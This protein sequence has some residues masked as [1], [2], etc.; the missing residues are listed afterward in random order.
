M[1]LKTGET[2]APN[3]ARPAD[4][5]RNDTAKA[6][7]RVCVVVMG[8]LGRSPRMLNHALELATAGAEVDLVGYA[9]RE[10]PS[11]IRDHDR[12]RCHRLKDS[13]PHWRHK[14][15]QFLFLLVASWRLAALATRL[16]WRLLW[17][18]E[19]PQY[20]LV[21]TP[22]AL[23]ALIVVWVASRLR[24]ATFVID[25]HNFG[26]TVLASRLGN[27]HW[28][29][30]AACRLEVFLARR[31]DMHF[32]VSEAMRQALCDEWGLAATYRLYDL[33]R[34]IHD[35]PG[36]EE[37][38]SI[39]SRISAQRVRVT[40]GTNVEWSV[41][42]EAGGVPDT[43]NAASEAVYSKEGR[44]FGSSEVALAVSS[45]SW[46]DDEDFG[47]LL[48]A[49]PLVDGLFVEQARTQGHATSLRLE[50]L[51]TGDGPRR[52]EFETSARAL[53]LV[54]IR[55]ATAWLSAED[56]TRLLTAADVGICLHRS[57]SGMDL[58]MKLSDMLGAGLPV[59][60]LDYGGA[61][62]E[63]L[64]E[65]NNAVLFHSP[66]SLAE[67]IYQVLGNF[68]D[69]PEKLRTLSRHIRL[70]PL[71]TWREEWNHVAY[72]LFFAAGDN[73]VTRS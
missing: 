7:L 10:L 63:R 31:G 48:Q 9:G 65:G 39:L 59:C 19:R 51:V 37:R 57:T 13:D 58:P 27:D 66:K 15:P 61:L 45:T 68:P 33:P 18:I 32:C 23:P 54:T 72:P 53:S 17:R 8:D 69:R 28:L 42:P 52:S 26:H 67:K 21:Q 43:E 62:H 1:A 50:M 12:I 11:C 55:I 71:P 56:Y 24:R 38:H 2:S 25:W 14:L 3:L 30:R 20:L 4:R 64:S 47:L 60:A 35:R 70:N 6:G 41:A 49:L 73:A 29:V 46:S 34:V 16:L 5:E 40:G 36:P 44:R 22:P